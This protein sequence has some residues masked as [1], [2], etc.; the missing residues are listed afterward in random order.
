MHHVLEQL[1]QTPACFLSIMKELYRISKND[2]VI[3]NS[4]PASPHDDSYLTRRMFAR[5]HLSCLL[6]STRKR[7]VAG[8][9]WALPISTCASMRCQLQNLQGRTSHHSSPD[10]GPQNFGAKGPFSLQDAVSARGRR[11]RIVRAYRWRRYRLSR[12]I[13]P[14]IPLKPI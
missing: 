8:A 14:M 2:V 1:G 6:C 13:S 4:C 10:R 9:P 3:E 5:L 11:F 7:T 12:M